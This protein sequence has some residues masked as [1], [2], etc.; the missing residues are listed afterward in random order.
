MTVD[1]SEPTDRSAARD[2]AAYIGEDLGRKLTGRVAVVVALVCLAAGASTESD[3]ALRTAGLVAGGIG[4]VAV[5][6]VAL[7]NPGRRT[8]WTAILTTLLVC[9]GLTVAMLLQH[10]AAVGV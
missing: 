3:Q 1:P 9:G 8:Q 6:L 7:S 5:L 4:V 2:T 10:R